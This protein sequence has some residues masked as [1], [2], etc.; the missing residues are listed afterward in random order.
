M[1][2]IV[3]NSEGFRQILNLPATQ[4]L[5]LE[6]AQK[7][8]DRASAS[9]PGSEGFRASSR[10]ASTRYIAFAGTTDNASCIAESENKALSKAVIP[11][12]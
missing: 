9:A 1:T 7:I 2:K 5:V 10:K 4:A 3:F 12:G 6:E 8:A 11:N